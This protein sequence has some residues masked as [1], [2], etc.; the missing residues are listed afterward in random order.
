VGRGETT[1]YVHAG[2]EL[3]GP[4]D[5]LPGASGAGQRATSTGPGGG[6]GAPLL[7]ALTRD[8]SGPR[9]LAFRRLH[10]GGDGR[11]V[12][13]VARLDL[14]DPGNRALAD[15]LLRFRLPWPPAIATDLRAV[16]LRTIQAGTIERSVY[17][18]EDRSHEIGFAARL[19]VELGIEASSLDVARRLVDATAWTHGSPERRRVDCLASARPG[20]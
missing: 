2:A 14:R 9:E 5:T 18:V 6:R 10:A 4:L 16:L 15:R 12:E 3:A 7:L 8:A 19:A 1:L 13:T 20:A 17:A 11:V